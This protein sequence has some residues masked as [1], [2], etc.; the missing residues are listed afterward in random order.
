MIPLNQLESLQETVQAAG[1]LFRQPVDSDPD[2]R[3][4]EENL[5]AWRQVEL[6]VSSF[7]KEPSN[8]A[9]KGIA[10]TVATIKRMVGR[11][12]AYGPHLH[13][14]LKELAQTLDALYSPGYMV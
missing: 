5:S 2:N 14:R 13:Q 12:N 10:E 1:Q 8:E 6:K 7:V 11:L 9:L 3:E 4:L